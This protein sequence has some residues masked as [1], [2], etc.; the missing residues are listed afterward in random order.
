VEYTDEAHAA[1][2]IL[3]VLAW[4]LATRQALGIALK[5]KALGYSA[6]NF[7]QR[8]SEINEQ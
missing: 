4:P 5:E 6:A 8:F 2:K 1:S 3:T 7:I